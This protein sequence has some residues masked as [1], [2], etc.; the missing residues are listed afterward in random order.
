MPD[1][2]EPRRTAERRLTV[3][4]YPQLG[5]WTL[6]WGGEKLDIPEL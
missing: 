4:A 2:R 6:D 1:I 5:P 3:A